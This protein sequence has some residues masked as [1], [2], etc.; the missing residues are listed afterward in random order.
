M[1]T[2]PSFGLHLIEALVIWV[3]CWLVQ[4]HNSMPVGRTDWN[5]IKELLRE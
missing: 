4:E 2:S 5:R 1:S 3:E